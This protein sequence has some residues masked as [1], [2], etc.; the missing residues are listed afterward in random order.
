[1]AIKARSITDTAQFASG[2]AESGGVRNGELRAGR[3]RPRPSAVSPPNQRR[4]S[5][6]STRLTYEYEETFSGYPSPLRLPIEIWD[7]P[8]T[9]LALRSR[10]SALD[11]R[12]PKPQRVQIGVAHHELQTHH[13]AGH[14]PCGHVRRFPSSNQAGFS[15]GSPTSTPI[16]LERNPGRKAT[17]EMDHVSDDYCFVKA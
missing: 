8:S 16:M 1:M 17:D 15:L 10:L 11:H 9:F 14:F 6:T 4:Q 7:E 12:L 5:S 3:R 13:L 2:A